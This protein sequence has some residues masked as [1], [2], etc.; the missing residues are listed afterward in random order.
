MKRFLIPAML[1][2]SIIAASASIALATGA[3]DFGAQVAAVAKAVDNVIDGSHGAA[4]SALA[5]TH[6]A[7][8]SAAARANGD[9]HAAAKG[10]NGATASESGRLKAAA[11]AA[12][13]P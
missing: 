7:E 11:G 8:V 2:T 9:A 10:D 3:G 4:V 1:A 6:G 12:N 13:R 5:K